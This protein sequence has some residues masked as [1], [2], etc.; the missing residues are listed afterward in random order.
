MVG[1]CSGTCPFEPRRPGFHRSSRRNISC[2]VLGKTTKRVPLR[3]RCTRYP[4]MSPT[5]PAGLSTRPIRSRLVEPVVKNSIPGVSLTLS[6]TSTAFPSRTGLHFLTDSRPL[7][8][9][10]ARLQLFASTIKVCSL[11]GILNPAPRTSR[12]APGSLTVLFST[13][14]T[15]ER[16][17]RPSAYGVHLITASPN[18]SKTDRRVNISYLVTRFSRAHFLARLVARL[19]HGKGMATPRRLVQVKSARPANRSPSRSYVASP[20]KSSSRQ[21]PL[22]RSANGSRT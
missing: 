2:N 17:R 3:P 12:S 1:A 4:G 5:S 15:R 18:S 7:L 10:A 21:R 16:F 13:V 11:H 6:A 19:H 20:I 8:R 9:H 22:P 14:V